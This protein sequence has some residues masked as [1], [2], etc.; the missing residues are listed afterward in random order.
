MYL[1]PFFV[2]VLSLFEIGAASAQEFDIPKEMAIVPKSVVTAASTGQAGLLQAEIIFTGDPKK[3]MAL[4]DGPDENVQLNTISQAAPGSDWFSFLILSGCT[5]D[6]KGN[7][8]VI[9]SYKTVALSGEI[10]TLSS[11]AYVLKDK[12]AP[13]GPTLGSEHRV[14]FETTDTPGVY[15]MIA[16]IT[17]LHSGL[18]LDLNKRIRL[19]DDR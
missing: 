19:T 7:C 1:I 4:W 16:K 2:V 9:V 3:L 18:E 11:P 17:D 13:N 14:R 15:T 10:H 8:S 6:D 12:P 5:P